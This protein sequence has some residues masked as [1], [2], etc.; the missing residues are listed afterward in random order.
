MTRGGP[1][2]TREAK[3][4]QNLRLEAAAP[5]APSAQAVTLGQGHQLPWEW[6]LLS[7]QLIIFSKSKMKSTFKAPASPECLLLILFD[8]D[9]VSIS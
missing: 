5:G 4:V 8:L 3:Q 6:P 1:V 7:S 9:F 2:L